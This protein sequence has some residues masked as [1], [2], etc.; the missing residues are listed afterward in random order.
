ML[1]FHC[2]IDTKT[3]VSAVFLPPP[4]PH[5]RAC[6]QWSELGKDLFL[7]WSSKEIKLVESHCVF[8]APIERRFYSP[9]DTKNS[10]SRG[11]EAGKR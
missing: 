11:E 7:V 9:L 6:N 2:C 5:W 10:P 8:G 1:V 4:L 3:S